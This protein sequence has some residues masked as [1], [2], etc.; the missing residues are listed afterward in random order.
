MFAATGEIVA[1]A[2]IAARHGGIYASHIRSESTAILQAIDEAIDIGARA[3][4]PVEISHFKVAGKS[5]WGKARETIAKVAAARARG[6][7]V[8]AD[9][10]AYAASST[11]LDALLPNWAL[12]GGRCQMLKRIADRTLRARIL[13]DMR[14]N[15]AARG[16]ADL[17]YARIASYSPDR[18]LEGKTLLEVTQAVHKR[19]RV[20][21]EEQLEGVLT[22]L[23]RG[24]ASMVFHTMSPQDVKLILRQPWVM[25]A[26]DSAMQAFG[27]GRPHPRGYGN[28]ARVLA[29]YVREEHVLELTDAI[30]K[31][32]SLPADTFH[33]HGRGRLVPGAFAD[34]VLFDPR[35]IADRATFEAPHAYAQ[36]VSTVV[37]N[38][39]LTVADGKLTGARAGRALRREPPPT[40]RLLSGRSPAARSRP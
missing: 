39:A 21:I 8:N 4:L 30:R 5:L 2:R 12:A 34:F 3:H 31:M 10:Y 24:R 32:T 14:E 27:Q 22:L 9:E 35:R 37:V 7:Q 38:G 36:G 28:N 13:R 29:R 25:I 26:S 40:A 1:L 6:Q 15:H 33:L 18:S 16:F 17:G 19:L 23:K 20:S 11:T